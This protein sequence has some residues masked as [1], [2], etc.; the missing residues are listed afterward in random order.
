MSRINFSDLKRKEFCE[1]L[2]LLSKSET[3]ADADFAE[4]IYIAL[5]KHGLNT[6]GIKNELGLS[7]GTI[8]RW[9]QSQN[10]PQGIARGKILSIIKKTLELS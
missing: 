7:N 4:L 3:I 1:F 5:T 6:V 10:L 2:S 9:M 8:E